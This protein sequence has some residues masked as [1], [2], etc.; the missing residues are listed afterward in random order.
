MAETRIGTRIKLIISKIK[1]DTEK[2]D[3]SYFLL[4]DFNAQPDS[5][6]I[7]YCKENSILK[8]VDLTENSGGT[9]HNFGRLAVTDKIDYIFTDEKNA[10]GNAKL[11]VWDEAF[12][13]IYLS[14]HYPMAIVY[15]KL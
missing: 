15:D 2:I 6:T 13:G 3:M 10:D 8:M 12:A 14:D 1:E 4:G 9:F 5:E 7:K 11:S